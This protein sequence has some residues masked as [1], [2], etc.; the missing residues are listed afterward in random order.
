MKTISVVIPAFNEERYLPIC[1][2]SIISQNYPKNDFEIIVVDNNSTDKTAEIANSFGARVI[3]EERQGNTFAVS[4][5]MKNAKNEIIAMTDADTV[6]SNDWLLEIDKIFQ[7]GKIAAATG[8]ADI[9][10]KSKLFN[11]ASEFFYE[12]FLKFNYL[13]GRPHITGFNLVVR[14]S[15]YQ[16]VGGI[17]ERF[18]M[19]PDVDLGLRIKKVGK[20]VF[21]KKLKVVT[22]IRRWSQN[23]FKTFK[24]YII[25]YIYTV[26]LR[27][28]PPV[29]QNVIR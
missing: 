21:S 23:P 2:G 19:S 29:K 13:L 24:T 27:K 3:R 20:V 17:D 10:T 15:A 16:A 14:R 28:P 25:G 11:M 22:S 9:A 12:V 5:G 7:D 26:W 1:L 8:T 6:A 4:T 18:T